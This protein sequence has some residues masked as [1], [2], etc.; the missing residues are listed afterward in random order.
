[1]EMRVGIKGV[2]AAIREL[3]RKQKRVTP[4]LRGTLN[5]TATKTRTE[6]FVKPLSRYLA[7]KNTR[8]AIRHRRADRRELVAR[9]VPSGKSVPVANYKQWGFENAG[10]PT[11]ARI[12]VMG[13]KGRKTAAGFVNPASKHQLPLA[14]WFTRQKKGQVTRHSRK[15]LQPAPGLSVAYWFKGLMTPSTLVWTQRFMQKELMRRI[16]KEL[17]K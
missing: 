2:D 9:L 1:M 13:P 3:E 12:W 6:R 8:S 4:I 15:S 14:T 17:N 10:H 7:A 16:E 11:R 5:S